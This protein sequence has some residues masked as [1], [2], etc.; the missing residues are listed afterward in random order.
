MI[1]KVTNAW[2]C[3]VNNG[4]VVPVFGD[5]IFNNA[6]IT[7]IA[8]KSFK[9][10]LVSKTNKEPQTFDAAGS[11]VTIPNVN[12]HEHIYSRLAKGLPVCG[13][14]DNFYSILDN[15]WWKL[16]KS[17][18]HDMT[19]ASAELA[20]IESIKNGVTYIFDHHA[21]PL[22]AKGSLGIL[23]EALAS[24]KLRS[25]LTHE[26]SDRNGEKYTNESLDENRDFFLN[27]VDDDT[28]ALF[29]LHAP[30]TVSDNTLEAT[31][32]FIKDYDLGIHIHLC[33][34][35]TDRNLSMKQYGN[36]PL[37]R[38]IKHKLLDDKSILAH[39]V[40]MSRN[41]Y[42][43]IIKYGSAVAINIDSN[44]NNSVG[45]H[46]FKIIPDEL[47]IVCGTDGMHANPVRTLKNIFLLMRNSGI[48]SD[49]AFSEI[50]KIYLN[51]INFVKRFFKDYGSLNK[52]DRS[53]F[54]IWDY[55]PPT[56]INKD[57]FW[58]HYIYGITESSVHS[59]IRSGRFLM[60][61]K[62]LVGINEQQHMKNIYK[63]GQRL[64]EK[65]KRQ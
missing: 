11:V 22:N 20:A 38:L 36:D 63:Q 2:I 3:R 5:I 24:F 12:F 30:F 1:T 52:N 49:K 9:N 8:R 31:H 16:D 51:Q 15:I 7:K 21:S 28:K 6:K 34:D 41:E 48:S 23:A 50:Q 4:E 43:R 39:A 37:T 25:V 29:G 46:N 45:I 17:L 57:N 58:G 32:K 55:S 14:T 40:H 10:Y 35:E 44:L 62:K 54:I 47:M 53:D 60:K 64:F 18:D 56:P 65:F 19:H 61:N 33:E 59:V 26:T 27:H 42:K 13:K